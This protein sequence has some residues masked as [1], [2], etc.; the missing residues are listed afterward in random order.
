MKDMIKGGKSDKLSIEDIA[1]KHS[2]FVGTIQKQIEMGMKVEMEHT[3]DKERAREISM[4][5]L[6]EFPDYYTRLDEL[7]EEAVKY[8]EN[9]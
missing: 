3:N 2:V 7:E 5:H 9:K 4:D 1:R 6:S 8:W